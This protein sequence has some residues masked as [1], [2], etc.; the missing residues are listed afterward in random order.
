MARAIRKQT[1]EVQER[2][3]R[4]QDHA[5]GWQS[6]VEKAFER[7]Q[8]LQSNMDQLD[9]RLDRAEETKAG[10]QPVGDLLIDSL[11]DH[12]AKTT[13]RGGTGE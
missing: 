9:L 11:Q 13:V 2:W 6:Q 7:L 5:G 4:L 8:E 10:L 12:I 1:A 3:E